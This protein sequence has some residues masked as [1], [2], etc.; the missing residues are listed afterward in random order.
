MLKILNRE[1]IKSFRRSY[2]LRMGITRYSALP[3]EHINRY[4][5]IAPEV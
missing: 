5:Y 1:E 2:R 3:V 4:T